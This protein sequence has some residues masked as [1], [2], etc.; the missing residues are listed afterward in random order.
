MKREIT[1]PDGTNIYYEEGF[2]TGKKTI[3]VNGKTLIKVRKNFYGDG[4]VEYRLKGNFYSGV[5]LI[6]PNKIY[7]I[8]EKLNVFEMLLSFIPLIMVI[9]GGAIGA[10]FGVLAS[11][12]VVSVIRSTKN[13]WVSIL[14]SIAASGVAFVLWFV[15][16]T[17]LLA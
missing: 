11:F 12:A 16:A 14:T 1:A 17:L 4:D 8:Y 7:T 15:V 5:E 9:I 10:V 2:W 13:I 6:S 3:K